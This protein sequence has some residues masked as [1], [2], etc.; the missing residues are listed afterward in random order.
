MSITKVKMSKFLCP[1]R[2]QRSRRDRDRTLCQPARRSLSAALHVWICPNFDNPYF[3]LIQTANHRKLELPK[4]FLNVR[5]CSDG[6]QPQ[7]SR[8]RT[9][10]KHKKHGNDIKDLENTSAFSHEHNANTAACC[11]T[12]LSHRE[13]F[14]CRTK[15]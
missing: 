13:C 6:K 8:N 14:H 15:C 4:A 5:K 1:N 12:T 7:I 2:R 9:L 11:T 3:A 10:R